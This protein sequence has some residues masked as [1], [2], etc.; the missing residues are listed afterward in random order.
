MF[1]DDL[2][3]NRE[4]KAGAAAGVLG[5]H[6]KIKNFRQELWRDTGPGVCD[7]NNNA[8]TLLLGRRSQRLEQLGVELVTLR[9]SARESTELL[10]KLINTRCRDP[11]CALINGTDSAN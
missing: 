9:S 10:S 5:R 2:P 1:L 11:L 3:A 6:E 7:L 8:G 4:S